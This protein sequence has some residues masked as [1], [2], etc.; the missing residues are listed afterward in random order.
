MKEYCEQQQLIKESK[1]KK[2]IKI[3]NSQIE[4]CKLCYEECKK[5]L[6]QKF[7]E[8]EKAEKGEFEKYIKSKLPQIKRNT[9]KELEPEL[10][11]MIEKH[12]QELERHREQCTIKTEKLRQTIESKIQES[13]VIEKKRVAEEKKCQFESIDTELSMKFHNLEIKHERE[14]DQSIKSWRLEM[15]IE[16]KL[17]DE[18]RKR[19]EVSYQKSE[20]DLRQRYEANAT[21]LKTTNKL[22]I[23]KIRFES[24]KK[25]ERTIRQLQE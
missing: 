10:Q 6:H 25:L 17:Y 7:K 19:K 4:Q 20:Q 21:E 16:K 15:D 9:A 3:A 23:E 13:V 5:Q 22:K 2:L 11:M 1:E 12:K 18:E 8:W 24:T 14:I